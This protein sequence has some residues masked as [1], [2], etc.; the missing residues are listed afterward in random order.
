MK[1]LITAIGLIVV[2][3]YLIGWA[4]G[5]VFL[6]AALLMGVLCYWEYSGLVAA[7]GV[8]RSGIFGLLAGVSLVFLPQQALT[9]G[10]V[11]FVCAFLMGLRLNNL[12]EVL[13]GV[14]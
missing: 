3:G 11:L 10:S 7:H 6:G 9:I 13:P 1:R 12:R 8:P 2:A 4:P 14:A 5:P